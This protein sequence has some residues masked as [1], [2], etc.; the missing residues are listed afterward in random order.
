MQPDF[1]SL[2]G[3]TFPMSDE[4][5]KPRP[6]LTT[7]D[8][9]A[10]YLGVSRRTAQDREKHMGLPI[11][12]L[13]GDKARVWAYPAE[14]DDWKARIAVRKVELSAGT[15]AG[16]AIGE[17]PSASVKEAKPDDGTPAPDEVLVLSPAPSAAFASKVMRHRGAL[18]SVLVILIG[19]NLGIVAIK[20]LSQAAREPSMVSLKGRVLEM[21]D[22]EN[23]VIWEFTLDGNPKPLPTD[24]QSDAKPVI[25]DIDGDGRKVLLYNFLDATSEPDPPSTLVC[26]DRSGKIRW[27]HQI[28]REIRTLGNPSMTYPQHYNLMWISTLHRP[29]P[30]GG[31]IVVGARRGG[32]S[33]FVVEILTKDGKMVGEYY[34]PGWLWA[35]AAIDLDEDGFDE[36]VLGGVNNAYG[37]LAGFDHPMTLV[38]LDSRRV[39]GQG[40]APATDNRHFVGLASGIERAVLLFRDFGPQP[41]DGPDDFSFFREIHPSGRHFEAFAVMTRP[42]DAGVDYQFDAHLG[43][44]SALPKGLVKQLIESKIT[45]PLT[46]IERR[47][48]YL[49]KFGDIRVLRNDLATQR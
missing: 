39:E 13:P 43:L 1:G 5:P 26:F 31:R 28:G 6:E 44:E 32:T 41:P 47:N 30:T 15:V 2:N 24:D 49:E 25:A 18:A 29:T 38:V 9:I 37:N 34:H 10:K 27:K 14:L 17:S 35:M 48:L 21:Q 7:W 12:R 3:R 33:V 42:R 19:V 45:K 40:P 36:I 11:Q 20:H 4:S 8:E 46:Q 22:Q 23:K 16:R